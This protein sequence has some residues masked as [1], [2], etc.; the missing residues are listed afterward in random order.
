MDNDPEGSVAFTRREMLAAGALT[1]AI[2][3]AGATAGVAGAAAVENRL[4]FAALG[5]GDGW[6]GWQAPGV[7]NLR[8][9]GGTGLL[10]AGSDVFPNDPRP[11]AFPVDLR[12][13]DGEVTAVIAR[14]GAGPGVVLRRV[15]PARLLRRDRR[16]PRSTCCRFPRGR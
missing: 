11:V 3:A 1:G 5:D 7:A 9:A 14:L 4:D 6:P 8:R 16:R 2:V 12:F 13:R 10:E 15:G